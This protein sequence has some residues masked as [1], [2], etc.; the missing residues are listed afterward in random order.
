MDEPDIFV[1]IR[2]ILLR[3][4][5]LLKKIAAGAPAAA[6]KAKTTPK[7]EP[8]ADALIIVGVPRYVETN[9]SGWT[10][11]KINGVRLSTKKD[12]FAMMLENASEK[13]AEVEI[14]FSESKNG[15]YINRRIE[16]MSYVAAAEGGASAEPDEDDGPIPF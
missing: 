16:A 6:K 9:S 11:C 15:E 7:G 4:E 2:D 10:N 1:E 12:H 3:Q 8:P 13:N 5:E 14:F